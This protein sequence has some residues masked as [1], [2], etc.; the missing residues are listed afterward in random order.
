MTFEGKHPKDAVHTF[1]SRHAGRDIQK[2]VDYQY[3]C[4][5]TD[6]GFAA[7]LLVP[8]FN[9]R[10]YAGSA[11]TAKQAETEAATRF[12]ADPDVL[13]AARSLPPPMWALRQQARSTSS[14]L[15]KGMQQRSLSTGAL[16]EICRQ[17][18]S[19]AYNSY[20]DLGCRMAVWDGTA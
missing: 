19:H 14:C 15:A 1:L 2:G 9:D 4:E 11:C 7:T 13:E 3:Q 6:L 10:S 18:A 8:V 17:K 20:R 12:L 16:A 5:S